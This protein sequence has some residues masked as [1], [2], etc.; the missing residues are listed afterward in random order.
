VKNLR[1]NL[2]NPARAGNVVKIINISAHEHLRNFSAAPR[3]RLSLLREDKDQVSL[4]NTNLKRP[5]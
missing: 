4:R 2:Y 1:Y 5:L 3:V